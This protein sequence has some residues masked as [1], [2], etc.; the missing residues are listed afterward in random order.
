MDQNDE[1][2]EEEDEI[3]QQNQMIIQ[4][5]ENE[6]MINENE[7][8]P[9]MRDGYMDDGQGE[10]P[11]GAEYDQEIDYQQEEEPMFNP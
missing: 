3:P 6:E 4:D 5:N 1:Y 11:E 9:S 7:D 2:A 10:A 8:E